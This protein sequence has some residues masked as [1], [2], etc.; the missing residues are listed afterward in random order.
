MS[1]RFLEKAMD[2]LMT[3][4]LGERSNV[5]NGPIHMVLRPCWIPRISKMAI[6][7]QCSL[8]EDKVWALSIVIDW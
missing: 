8:R 5:L 4:Y 7:G 1:R 6:T 3:S 2:T